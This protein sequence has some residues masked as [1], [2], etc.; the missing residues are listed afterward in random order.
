MQG[1]AT[2]F[3][4]PRLATTPRFFKTGPSLH[5]SLAKI[6]VENISMA[7][8]LRTAYGSNPLHHQSIA[9]SLMNS[10]T[11]YMACSVSRSS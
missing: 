2:L 4:Q 8:T 5:L 6:P 1:P 9:K 7:S 11:F 3:S 10:H